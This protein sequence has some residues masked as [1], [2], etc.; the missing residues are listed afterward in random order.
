[1]LKIGEEV[2]SVVIVGILMLVVFM[3]AILS[4]RLSAL[5]ALIVIPICAACICNSVFWNYALYRLV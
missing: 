1:M 4:K 5:N 3:A 2:M